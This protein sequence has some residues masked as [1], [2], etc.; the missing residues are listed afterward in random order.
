Y[1]AAGNLLTQTDAKGQVTTYVYDALNRVPLTALPDG[2]NQQYIYDTAVN[3]IGRLASI[4]ELDPSNQQVNRTSYSYDQHGRVTNI[5]TL[6]AGVTYNLAYSYDSFGRLSGLTYP[7]GRTV[8]YGFDS[9]GR[10]SSVTTTKPGD[11]PQP[12]VSAVAYH[13]FGGVKSYTLGNGRV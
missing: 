12:V 5:A 4:S 3:G 9:L 10:V 13:P 1:D 2:S 8:A 6:H 7:S 11:S